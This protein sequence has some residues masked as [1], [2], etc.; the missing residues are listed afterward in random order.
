MTKVECFEASSPCGTQPAVPAIVAS[1]RERAFRALRLDLVT[2]IAPP[3]ERPELGGY[4]DTTHIHQ[5]ERHLFVSGS[6]RSG[7]FRK[8]ATMTVIFGGVD[9]SKGYADFCF[10]NQAGSLLGQPRRHDDTP[11]GHCAVGQALAELKAAHGDGICFHVGLESSGGL[12]RNWLAMFRALPDCHTFQLNPLA[13]KRYLQSDLHA[14]VDD[15][16]SARGIAIYLQRGLRRGERRHEPSDEG[17]LAL[18]RHAKNS[19]A[20]C[21]EMQN[22]LQS[23]LPAVHPY[24]VQ[25]CRTGMPNWVLLLLARYP[26][27]PALARA[28]VAVVARIPYITT[29]RATRL[30]A[31]AKESI[32]AL[33]DEDTG[34][35]IRALAQAIL[36]SEEE[37]DRLKKQVTRSLRDHG[38]VP[39]LQSIPGIGLWTASTLWLE[40]GRLERFHSAAAVVA[41]AGLDPR[42][43][44]SGDGERH[45]G[46]SRAGRKEVRVA[47]YM[48]ALTAI[49][50]NP[51]IRAYYSRLRSRGKL[52]KVAIVACMAKL[53]RI[54]YA[55][56]VSGQAFD[57][58][59]HAEVAARHAAQQA[60]A[61]REAGTAPDPANTLVALEAPITRR[62]ASRRRAAA[63]PQAGGNLRAR[64]PGAAL[65]PHDTAAHPLCQYVTTT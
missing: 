62:E 43:R 1:L 50:D 4:P 34:A 46:I 17:K 58:S 31:D 52:H 16:R 60:E 29:T 32:A 25:Y 47:L 56:V 64:G 27:A 35:A 49:R 20:R 42:V 45:I 65:Q 6:P 5:A 40:L 33:R 8:D 38:Q 61:A 2:K 9:V 30:I 24:L 7:H 12:E 11:A 63:M 19:I 57:A 28:H 39:L 55:C 10:L 53:L 15:A 26:T 41:F 36:R 13:V 51:T 23:L 14:H 22:E 18:C 21:A 37:N 48:A 59:R 3:G 44:Q 54:A